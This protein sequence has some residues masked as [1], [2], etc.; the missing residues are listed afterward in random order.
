MVDYFNAV[1]QKTDIDSQEL[2]DQAK[3]KRRENFC[4]ENHLQ[5]KQMKEVH[6]L[7]I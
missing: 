7:C 6:A 4:R 1:N 2:L 5:L 3:E